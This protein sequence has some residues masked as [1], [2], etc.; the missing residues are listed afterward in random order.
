M[1]DWLKEA[2][3]HEVSGFSVARGGVQIFLGYTI[4]KSG[5]VYL[6]AVEV[7]GDLAPRTWLS[8][9]T[10]RESAVRDAE[11]MVC[12]VEEYLDQINAPVRPD[13]NLGLDDFIEHLSLRLSNGLH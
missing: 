3:L 5:P 7:M 8:R 10:T 2:P 12:V 4:S 9:W 13:E 1:I 11:D 6:C